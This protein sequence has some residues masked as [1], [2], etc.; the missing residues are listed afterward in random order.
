M[1][2]CQ[3]LLR[4]NYFFIS[5]QALWQSKIKR[6]YRPCEKLDQVN[7]FYILET[8]YLK[9]IGG[10]KPEVKIQGNFSNIEINYVLLQK[11]LRVVKYCYEIHPSCNKVASSFSQ[12]VV[13]YISRDAKSWVHYHF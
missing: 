2:L 12:A 10:S 13:G 3:S 6:K 5:N 4:Q 9:K 8:S 11:F 1:S 7:S